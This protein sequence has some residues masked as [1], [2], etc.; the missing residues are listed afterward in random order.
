MQRLWASAVAAALAWPAGAGAADWPAKPVRLIVPFAAGGPAD[1]AGRAYAEVLGAALGQ[2]FIVENRTGGGGIPAV[3]AVARGEPDGYT[4]LVSGT[5][6]LVLQPAMNP[7]ISYDPVRDFTHIAYFG[8]ISNMA[9]VHPSLGVRTYPEFVARV[10]AEPGG[11]EYLSAGFGSMGYWVGQ[12]IAAKEDIKLTHV[13]Y[14]GGSVAVT[15]LL[16]GHVKVGMLSFSSSAY[17]VR[18]GKLVALAAASGERLPYYAEL[19]T[20]AEIWKSDFASTTWFALS[21]PPGM[22]ADI[23][24]RLNREVVK[25]MDRPEVRKQVE[26]HTIESKAMTPSEFTAFLVKERERWT[27]IIQRIMRETPQ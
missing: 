12:Y 4:L 13:P 24:E 3:E 8:G 6:N 26:N 23:V 22:A 1:A 21:G 11:F 2:Q 16:A 20:L 5:P 9:I 7:A 17:H 15:D 18:E 10:R 25:A 19:P 27:P 14:R